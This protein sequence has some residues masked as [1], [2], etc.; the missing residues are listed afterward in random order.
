MLVLYAA[1]IYLAR[2]R[3]REV[4]RN[5][6]WCLIIVGLLILVVR[7]IVGHYLVDSLVANA[8]VRPAASDA[9]QIATGLLKDVGIALVVY[10]ILV[11]LAACLAGPTRAA[12]AVRRF[13]APVFRQ[14]PAVVF[15]VVILVLCW[16]S[17]GARRRAGAPCGARCCSSPWC[18]WGSRSCAA[19]YCA[20]SPRAP[21][22]AS[23]SPG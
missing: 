19:R 16:S 18:W 6:G 12:V 8:A 23:P 13:L 7:R 22:A 20:S 11:V 3:R 10:G 4:L 9:W 14:H 2:G 15:G 5:I 21:A 17:C 1:A